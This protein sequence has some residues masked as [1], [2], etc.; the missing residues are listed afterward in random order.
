VAHPDGDRFG[1]LMS[2]AIAGDRQAYATLLVDVTPILRG[3]VSPK[4]PAGDVEDVVQEILMSLHAARHTYEPDRPFL[5][6]LFTIARRRMSDHLRQE[7]RQRRLSGADYTLL[8]GGTACTSQIEDELTV[9]TVLG[10]WLPALTKSQSTAVRLLKVHGL[11][12]AEAASE[13][14]MTT[15]ALKVAAHR[16][17]KTLRDDLVEGMT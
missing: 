8:R 1:V 5:P 13:S 17:M 3:L 6:W 7:Y 15:A 4:F 11:T 10:K 9:A 12:L 16:A 14:G 2:A